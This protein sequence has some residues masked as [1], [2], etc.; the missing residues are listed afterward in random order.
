MTCTCLTWEE[1]LGHV[2]RKP[3]RRVVHRE[4]RV[5]HR[6]A[7]RCELRKDVDRTLRQAT[8]SKGKEG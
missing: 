4:I 8:V 1:H 2:G 7:V 6:R 3:K 5:P